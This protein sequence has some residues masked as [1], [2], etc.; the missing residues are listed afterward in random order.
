MQL[1]LG[2][3]FLLQS[4]VLHVVLTN[5]AVLVDLGT[6]LPQDGLDG[7]TRVGN[8]PLPLSRHGALL[9]CHF[10]TAILAN[11]AYPTGSWFPGILNA[12]FSEVIKFLTI[13]V[14][15]RVR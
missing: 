7:A 10:P 6:N 4:V 9:A 12:K 14:H 15:S 2:E 1:Y 11:S 8:L 13:R 5:S 3:D